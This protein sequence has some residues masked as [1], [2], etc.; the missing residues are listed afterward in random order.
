MYNVEN[1][2]KKP[3]KPAISPLIRNLAWFNKIEILLSS[4][5]ITLQYDIVT[6]WQYN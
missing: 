5:N 3:T 2:L 6:Q 4:V 1:V